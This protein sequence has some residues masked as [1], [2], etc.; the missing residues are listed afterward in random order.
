MKKKNR[1]IAINGAPIIL[2]RKIVTPSEIRK[3]T[4]E[5][6][7]NFFI[8]FFV[9]IILIIFIYNLFKKLSFYFFEK[10]TDF[11]IKTRAMKIKIFTG[12]SHPLVTMKYVPATR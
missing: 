12:K 9:N 5:V 6:I 10:A 7:L 4:R 3:N 8:S 11:K 2:L 1:L